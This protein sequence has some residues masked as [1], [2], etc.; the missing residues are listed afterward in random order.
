M[1]R[2]KEPK[3][4][5]E[6]THQTA[7]LQIRSPLYGCCQMN[8][9]SCTR[10]RS[11]IDE[12]KAIVTIENTTSSMNTIFAPNTHR[13][14]MYNYSTNDARASSAILNKVNFEQ[15]A[16]KEISTV[17]VQD[18]DLL[19]Q[20]QLSSSRLTPI[21]EFCQNVPYNRSSDTCQKPTPQIMQHKQANPQHLLNKHRLQ[22]QTNIPARSNNASAHR[23]FQSSN[24]SSICKFAPR[25]TDEDY[26]PYK[27]RYQHCQTNEELISE[28]RATTTYCDYEESQDHS[29][30][31]H[32]TDLNVKAGPNQQLASE[33]SNRISMISPDF[34]NL[35]TDLLP[36]IVEGTN[37]ESNSII[38]TEE[39]NSQSTSP[40][41]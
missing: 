38:F 8:Q 2:S 24:Q 3:S 14:T 12:S 30:I 16:P 13:Q 1:N 27:G 36:E 31:D 22:N 35:R 9:I 4:K 33:D 5:G 10:N 40:I 6:K 25:H 41:H 39:N 17:S 19:V 23:E 34:S 32:W 18:R 26:S 15:V 29:L 20:P 21:G 37:E 11:S 28:D 7:R